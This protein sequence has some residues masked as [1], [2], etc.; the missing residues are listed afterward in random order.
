MRMIASHHPPPPTLLKVETILDQTRTN[1]VEQIIFQV[2]IST[3]RSK[4]VWC[5]KKPSFLVCLTS[6]SPGLGHNRL[7][8]KTIFFL[9]R[10]VNKK[11][12]RQKKGI[13]LKLLVWNF[14]RCPPY[15]N[16][17]YATCLSSNKIFSPTKTEVCK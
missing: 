11:L 4:F 14:F 7:R 17:G 16:S 15:W 9:V 6:F 8:T 5:G 10:N 12:Y 1:V 3:E 2:C 13:F